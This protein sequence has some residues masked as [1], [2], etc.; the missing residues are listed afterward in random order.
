MNRIGIMIVALSVVL[1]HLAWP[2]Q[3]SQDQ[4]ATALAMIERL[5]GKVLTDQTAPHRH[6]VGV[7]LYSTRVKDT[8]LTQLKAF[9]R[10]SPSLSPPRHTLQ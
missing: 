9:P 3:A 8:D 1:I 7:E 2:V 10:V 6:V 5:F 4:N